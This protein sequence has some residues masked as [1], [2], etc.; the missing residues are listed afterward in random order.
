MNFDNFENIII[1]IE[2]INKFIKD[3]ILKYN[4]DKL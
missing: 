3:K 2:F 1:I 4:K